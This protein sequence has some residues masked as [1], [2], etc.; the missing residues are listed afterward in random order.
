[1]TKI[2]R[3]LT[4]FTLLVFALMLAAPATSELHRQDNKKKVKTI[5]F[6]GNSLS[7]GYGVPPGKA[8]P[9]LIADKIDSLSWRFEVWNAGVSGETTSGGL[10]RIDWLLRREIDVLVLELGGNDALRGLPVE[11]TKKNLQAIIDKTRKAYPDAR[12][13]IAGMQAPPNLGK[14]YTSRFRAIY[15]QLAEENDAVLIPFLLEGVGGVPEL[16]LSDGI[17]PTAEGHRIIA[18]NV[19]KVLKPVLKKM[20]NQSR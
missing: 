1:M 11:L 9:E 18:E 15:P 12:I 3:Y 8:F 6:L 10:R 16:N 5:L 7:A 20:G 17:H 2:S 13:V 4:G 19:W 14:E